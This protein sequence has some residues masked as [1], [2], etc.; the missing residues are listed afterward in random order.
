TATSAPYTRSLHDA[1]PIYPP[2]RRDHA[3]ERPAS[4]RDGRERQS[5]SHRDVGNLFCG[6]V[7]TRSRI[8]P[9]Q[10]RRT[11]CEARLRQLPVR[12]ERSEE[13]TSELQSRGHLVCR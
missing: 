1:L 10:P 13:H 9:G 5:T 8:H 6:F 4:R 3:L 11:I 7:W 2:R 12:T